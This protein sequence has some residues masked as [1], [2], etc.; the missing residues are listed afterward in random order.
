MTRIVHNPDDDC[1]ARLR[2]AIVSG[3]L[4]PNERLVELELSERLGF[5]RAAIRT[6]LVRLEADGLVERERN[7]GAKVRMVSQREASEILE[8]RAVLE[9]LAA[10]HAALHATP[11]DV[12]RLRG[13]LRRMRELLDAGDLVGASDEQAVLHQTIAELSGHATAL[14]LISGL[15]SQV[16]RYQ[17]RT[18]LVPGRPGE[19]FEEHSA[20]VDAIAAGDPDAA[21]AAMRRHLANVA[22]TLPAE[23][24]GA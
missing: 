4:Q 14:R 13:V 3:E 19:S 17:Y 12:E 18:I 21:E 2:A 16:V 15:R 22:G 23:V 1:Y 9:G 10:R 20:I 7:R 24:P 6:A 8:A 11:E 5:G